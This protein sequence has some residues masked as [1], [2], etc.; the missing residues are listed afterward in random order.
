MPF[1]NSLF[2]ATDIALHFTLAIDKIWI[3]KNEKKNLKVSGGIERLNIL[4]F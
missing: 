3:A 2:F 1:K 4:F